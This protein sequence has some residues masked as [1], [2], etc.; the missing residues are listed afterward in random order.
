MCLRKAGF[1]KQ[2]ARFTHLLNIQHGYDSVWKACQGS[3]RRAVRKSIRNGV[4]V[5]ISESE[6]DLQAFYTIYLTMMQ[7]FKSP[8]KPYSL[9]SALQK[10]SIG[11][12]VIAEHQN[13]IIGGMLLLHFNKIATVWVIASMAQY[14]DLRPNNAL[15]DFIIR[16]ACDNGFSWVDLGASP[17]ERAGLIKFKESWNAER[18][19]FFTYQWIQSSWRYHLWLCLNLFFEVHTAIYRE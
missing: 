19:D 11:R 2:N 6:E 13:K 15:Y 14:L 9:L 17:P 3:V 5:S 16:W 18:H 7:I 4:S 10:S 1:I 8:P 12:L